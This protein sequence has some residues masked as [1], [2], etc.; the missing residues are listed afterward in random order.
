[1][2]MDNVKVLKQGKNRLSAHGKRKERRKNAPVK[3][4]AGYEY[5]MSEEQIKFLT[6]E[7]K[8]ASEEAI[9]KYL[10]Q[11]NYRRKIVSFTIG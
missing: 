2:K 11:G 4:V 10:N 5:R 7:C 3:S 8:L 6:E 9:L 1:M